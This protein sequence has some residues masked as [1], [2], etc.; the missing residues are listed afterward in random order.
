MK[1]LFTLVALFLGM[2][3]IGYSQYYLIPYVNAGQNPGG[4]NTDPEYPAGGGQVAGWTKILGGLN[5]TAAWSPVQTIPFS[6]EF[7][8]NPVTQYKV[9]SSGVLTFTTGASTVPGYTAQALPSASIPNQSVMAWGIAGLGSAG[10]ADNDFIHTKVFGTAPNRQLWVHFA[11]YSLPAPASAA[12]WTY[13]SI[14]LEESSNKIYV[15]DQRNNACVHKLTVGIQIDGSTAVTVSGAPN[16]NAK[17][18]S[19]P[20]PVDNTYYEFN[21]GTQP[22][23]DL[24]ASKV[25]IK[26]FVAIAQGPFDIKTQVMNLGTTTITSLTFNYSVNGGATVSSTINGLNIPALGKATITHPTQ[27]AVSAEGTYNIKAWASDLNGSNA[28]ENAANDTAKAET[29][30]VDNFTARNILQETFTSS[31]CPPCTPGNANFQEIIDQRDKWTSIKYQQNFPSPGND[32]YF[33]QQSLDRRNFYGVNSI[34]RLEIDG[35]W[36]DNSNLYTPAIFDSFADVPSFLDINSSYTVEGNK[37][38]VTA[39]LN[40]LT[41]NSSTTLKAYIVIVEDTTYNNARTNG[42]TIFFSVMKRMIPGA[43]GAAIQPLVSNTPQTVTGSY[44]FANANDVEDFRNLSVVVFVQDNSTKDVLQSA[45]AT[46]TNLVL[47][48]DNSKSELIDLKVFPNPSLGNTTFKL[49][50]ADNSQVSFEV[51]DIMGKLIY[52]ENKGSM[53]KG[54]NSFSWNADAS[55]ANGLYNIVMKVNGESTTKK[56][57]LNR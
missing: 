27:W 4:L 39:T 5:T 12:C 48:V 19:D 3:S 17:A 14:V 25:D 2:V 1:K 18:G 6:F 51:F 45:W 37:V 21:P 38:E 41:S 22:A 53:N 42:E 33:T 13:W 47:G 9:S 52:S 30:A 44:T 10:T 46:R 50:L 28:D 40:P 36:D 56:I 34:P 49:V 11:S 31:T 20:L 7:N 55:L 54:L 26:R 24:S 35:K 32:P 16:T 8:G 57:V 15:V 43:T 29:Q 23:F